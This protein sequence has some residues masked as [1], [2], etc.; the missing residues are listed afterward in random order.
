MVH[1]TFS[2]LHRAFDDVDQ[3]P[4]PY[5]GQKNTSAN[6]FKHI[7]LFTNYSRVTRR[8]VG[9][10]SYSSLQWGESLTVSHLSAFGYP[11][12]GLGYRLTMFPRRCDG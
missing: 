1:S 5:S 4:I 12:Q 6:R 8:V 11:K 7:L 3:F 9:Q 10:V 2:A